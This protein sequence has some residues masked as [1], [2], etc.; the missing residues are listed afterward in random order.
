ML[1]VLRKSGSILNHANGAG[2]IHFT[3]QCVQSCPRCVLTAANSI[4]RA[5]GPEGPQ[6]D[7]HG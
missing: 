6:G 2:I 1:A 4:R 5:L 3:L 7:D